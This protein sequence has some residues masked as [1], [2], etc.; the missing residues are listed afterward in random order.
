MQRAK[1]IILPQSC[2]YDLYR[3]C[4]TFSAHIFP[5]Y[6]NRF[7]YPG[8]TGQVRLFK[9]FGLSHP[10]S[11]VWSSVASFR[12]F[13]KGA[14][15]LPHEMPYLIKADIG[16][17][18]EGVFIVENRDTLEASLNRL[19]LKENSGQKGFI[20]QDLV[21]SEGN[22]L[23]A[24]IVGHR[25]F[26]YW[27]RPVKSGELITTLGRGAR[28]DKAWR[29]D[30]QDK[31]RRE[32]SSLSKAAG[33]NLAAVDFVFSLSEPEP[34]PLFLEI[35]YYFGRRGLGGSEQYYDILKKS[36][37]EWLREKGLDTKA[38]TLV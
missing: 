30:L 9:T 8:K 35:N 4:L 36:I 17:E 20:T 32:V 16:H 33:I 27:K 14:T 22:V 29:R 2:S 38:V 31:T 23:R 13:K 10:R 37:Q 1:A 24:V 18:G 11:F 19:S 6:G 5:D 21:R 26:T 25:I 7:R 28:I 12:A 34:P 15:H 3:A